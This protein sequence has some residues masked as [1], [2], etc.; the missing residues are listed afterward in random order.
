MVIYIF[1]FVQALSI[2]RFSSSASFPLIELH[3]YLSLLCM[4]KGLNPFQLQ[5]SLQLET[6][7]VKELVKRFKKG[8]ERSQRFNSKN[9]AKMCKLKQNKK[10]RIYMKKKNTYTINV[11]PMILLVKLGFI[12]LKAKKWCS[13][14]VWGNF[15]FVGLK[16]N[17]K[18]FLI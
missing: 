12:I 3:I 1:F 2:F 6:K 9:K 5:P 18:F 8:K 10:M 11:R 17:F 4:K 14:G 7:R 16:E 13:A 15:F